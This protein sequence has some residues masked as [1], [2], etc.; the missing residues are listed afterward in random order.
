MLGRRHDH[1]PWILI[2]DGAA[3]VAHVNAADIRRGDAQPDRAPALVQNFMMRGRR[4][5]A[6]PGL[7]DG[8][9]G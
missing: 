9:R 7:F 8:E 2:V 3:R 4:I 6:P 1:E 5:R